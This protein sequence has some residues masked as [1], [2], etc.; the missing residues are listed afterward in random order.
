M[1]VAFREISRQ[2]QACLERYL[3]RRF[4]GHG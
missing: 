1:G 3:M 4:L 2:D